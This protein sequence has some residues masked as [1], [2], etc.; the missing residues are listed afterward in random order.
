M[1]QLWHS[2]VLFQQKAHA[3]RREAT[4]KTI[5]AICSYCKAV[6]PLHISTT[7]DIVWY[8]RHFAEATAACNCM[9]DNCL[10]H[11]AVVT[12]DA[13]A[14][15]ALIVTTLQKVPAADKRLTLMQLVDASRKG[16]VT[17][18]AH[19]YSRIHVYNFCVWVS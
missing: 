18:P 4:A 17:L 16:Q 14:A 10:R 8:C 7:V 15:A 11:N 1:A 5:R 3:A 9:C 19:R 2:C 13:T 6:G 12:R